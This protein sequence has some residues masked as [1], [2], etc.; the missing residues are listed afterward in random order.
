MFEVRRIST[1]NLA[2]IVM[3]IAVILHM[4]IG[5]VV[6]G[7]VQLAQS[8]I[9]EWAGVSIAAWSILTIWFAGAVAVAILS[10]ILGLF[11]AFLYNMTAQWWG[12]LRVTLIPAALKKAQKQA[13]SQQEIRPAVRLAESD[14]EPPLVIPKTIADSSDSEDAP[15]PVLEKRAVRR[16]PK[17]TAS[18]PA[19]EEET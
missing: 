9:A 3:T 2:R 5:V 4:V 14:S 7:A 15:L 16:S 10:Y 18:V 8:F 6:A 12:G 11:A 17:K 1:K 19:I 13:V